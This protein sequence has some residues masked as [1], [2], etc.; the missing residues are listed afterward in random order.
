MSVLYTDAVVIFLSQ[1]QSRETKPGIME[2]RFCL[3]QHWM[4]NKARS[5]WA[6][7]TESMLIWQWPNDC[8]QLQRGASCL[9]RGSAAWLP[10]WREFPLFSA[11]I[12]IAWLTLISIVTT[13]LNKQQSLPKHD[14]NWHQA[15]NWHQSQLLLVLTWL[16]L[17]AFSTQGRNL[18]CLQWQCSSWLYWLALL[19]R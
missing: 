14:E 9:S 11:V 6:C 4:L 12:I 8:V 15:H 13:A 17:G 19:Q 10:N 2:M 18:E 1:K 5:R 3:C 16:V 7:A